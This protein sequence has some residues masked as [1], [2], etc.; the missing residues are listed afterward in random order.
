MTS[1]TWLSLASFIISLLSFGVAFSALWIVHLRRGTL[2]MTQ[3]TMLF[4]GRDQGPQ[5]PKLYLR[6]LLFSTSAKGQI[7]ENMY[8]R[9]HAPVAGQYKF[10]FWAYSEKDKI[11]RGSGLFVSQ[12]GVVCDNHFML[13]SGVSGSDT[14]FPVPEFLFW[15][16]E[17]TAEVFANILGRSSAVRLVQIQFTVNGQQAGEMSQLRDAG[18]FF[19]LDSETRSYVGHLESRIE[20]SSDAWK[21]F[22]A[23]IGADPASRFGPF[24]PDT[25]A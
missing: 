14:P 15:A 10:D 22:A 6:T 2:K 21:K 4:F 11:S 20:K 5:I 9:L 23:I 17:Y 13:R 7:I 18:I 8:V 1:A 24:G 25:D 12:S 16:G 3:P 19:D